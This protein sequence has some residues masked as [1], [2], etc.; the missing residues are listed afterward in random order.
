M[1]SSS[2]VTGCTCT[3]EYQTVGTN[4]EG[5]YKVVGATSIEFDIDGVKTVADY[6]AEGER[7]ILLWEEDDQGVRVREHLFKFNN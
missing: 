1:E 6:C 2:I 4:W 3:G 5:T 7:L